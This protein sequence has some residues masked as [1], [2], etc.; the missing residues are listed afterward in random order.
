MAETIDV[1]VGDVRLSGR[2]DGD[3]GRQPL[4]LLHALGEDGSDWDAVVAALSGTYRTYAVDLRGHGQSDWP[5]DYSFELMRDD[6]IG[7]LDQLGL[8]RVTLVAHSLGGS[9]AFLLAEHQPQRIER[10]VLEDSCPAYDREWT[11]PERPDTPLPFDWPVVPAIAAQAS[12]LVPERWDRLADITAPTLVVA[13]GPTSHVPQDKLADVAERIPDC[14]LVTIP[15]GHH[16]HR[17]APD[18][19]ITAARDFLGS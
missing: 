9:V 8:D 15:A 13:G 16:V 17:N 14:Q 5:G 2:L 3:P 19:F 6:V 4:L 18:E 12:V 1:T 10:L 7:F 11:V